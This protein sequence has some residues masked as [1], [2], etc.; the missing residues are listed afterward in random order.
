MESPYN[1]HNL[2][3]Y[4]TNFF[5]Q[6]GSIRIYEFGPEDGKKVLFVHGITTSCI[7]LKYLA[8]NLVDRG[9]RVMLFVS[10]AS[11]HPSTS[12]PIGRLHA[13]SHY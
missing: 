9:C 4:I 11:L 1:I 3:I 12:A 13:S 8:Q 6:Y 5:Y 10:C 7:T 2:K